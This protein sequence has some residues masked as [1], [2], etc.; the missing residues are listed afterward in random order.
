MLL[1]IIL[2]L[3]GLVIFNFFLLFFSC[4]KTTKKE[5]DNSAVA[6]P[7]KSSKVI[8]SQSVAEQLAPT[9]S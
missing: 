5:V 6:S 4:N 3:T 1:T 8:S 2:T 9:G 7:S